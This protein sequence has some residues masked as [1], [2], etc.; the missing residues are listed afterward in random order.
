[1][2]YR[3][4]RTVLLFP[5]VLLIVKPVSNLSDIAPSRIRCFFR[6]NY[7]LTLTVCQHCHTRKNNFLGTCCQKQTLF[8][9]LACR[10]QLYQSVHSN[11]ITTTV[12][13]P[14]LHVRVPSIGIEYIRYTHTDCGRWRYVYT[15]VRMMEAHFC[16]L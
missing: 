2:L 3:G 15:E 14:H 8:R 11:K 9:K 10:I 5:V 13:F 7:C 1:M 16:V 4:G 12:A 6:R